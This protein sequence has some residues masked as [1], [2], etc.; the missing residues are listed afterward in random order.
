MF[1]IFLPLGILL[2]SSLVVL[3][4]ISTTLFFTQL[5]WIGLGAILVA[6]FL[7][8][9]WRSIFN[10]RWLLT[11]LYV[12]VILLLIYV[13]VAGPTIRNIKG[14]IQVGSFTFQP[15]ELAKVALI[16]LYA[17]YF[18]R[19]HLSVGRWR[20]IFGSFAIF[21]VPALL[22]ILEPDLGATLI[23][24]GVWFGFLLV[25]GLPPRRIVVA[26]AAFA[27]MAV[28]LWF[29]GLQNYQRARITGFLYPERDTLGINYSTNQAK[30]AI[31]SAGLLGKGYGQ[32]SQTQLGFLSEPSEDFIL[33]AF[34]EEWGLVGGAVVIGAFLAL[35]I[36]IVRVG[37]FADKNFEKFLCIGTV[38]I[39]TLQFLFNAG[40]TTGLLPV[41]GVT[42]PFFSYGGSS[43]LVNFLLLSIINAI[44]VRS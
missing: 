30:I 7:F 37:A 15:T 16:F 4:S 11:A 23:L 5:V 34:I 24:F 27:V 43:L 44:R 31:G 17:Q 22:A 39:L 26:V 1:S 29:F 32:G 28:F 10:Y 19:R 41:V 42:F 20:T 9:D 14:W 35:L 25:S 6:L 36:G 8:I 40:S 21:L 33:A 2:A 3:S 12:V 13:L 18:S 38:I